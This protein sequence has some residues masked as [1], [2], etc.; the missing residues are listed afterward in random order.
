[1]EI[2]KFNPCKE[3]ISYRR[4]FSSFEKAWE[5]CP[6]GDWMLWIASKIL[7]GE[8][9]KQLF[10]AKALC[11]HTVVHWMSDKRSRN[12]IRAAFLY[13]RNK[14][15]KVELRDA[16]AAA[17]AAAYADADYAAANAAA[18]ADY[19]ADAAADYVAAYAANA[20]ADY[21]AAYAADAAADYAAANAANAADA[22]D[23]AA[24]AYAYIK[25]QNQLKTADICRKVLTKIVFER[26]KELK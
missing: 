13:G 26:I 9:R 24:D 12:A 19:A 16:Y 20:A 6:R 10:I 3:A 22:A 17:D 2:L 11:A 1:M 25:K 14:I 21:A 4:Q 15:S 5:N 23:A 8:D 18:D 7:K